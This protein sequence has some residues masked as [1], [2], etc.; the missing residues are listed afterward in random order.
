MLGQSVDSDSTINQPERRNLVYPAYQP[1]T[2]DNIRLLIFRPGSFD[3]CIHCQFE[4]VSLNDRHAYEALSYV[5]GNTSDTS[6]MRLD[7]VLYNIT[8][9][10]ECAL[11]YLRHKESLRVLWVDAVCT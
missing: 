11:R 10:L 9:N 7:G 4:Q 5:W 8:K 2:G 1:L 3:D 6:P